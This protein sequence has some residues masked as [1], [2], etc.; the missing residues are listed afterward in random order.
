MTLGNMEGV[1]HNEESRDC[2]AAIS[3]TEHF[4]V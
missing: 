4:N 1:S 2:V 3:I